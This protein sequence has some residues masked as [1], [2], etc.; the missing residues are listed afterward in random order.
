MSKEQLPENL[1]P[2]DLAEALLQKLKTGATLDPTL[3]H[4]LLESLADKPSTGPTADEDVKTA[5]SGTTEALMSVT[6]KVSLDS[7][8]PRNENET[9]V[10]R[11][12]KAYKMLVKKQTNPEF[13]EEE[14]A[15]SEWYRQEFDMKRPELHRAMI[16]LL[17]DYGATIDI[18]DVNY[19]FN[20]LSRG[21][22]EWFKLSLS[23]HVSGVPKGFSEGEL[24]EI[25][26]RLIQRYLDE[27]P[28]DEDD[29]YNS[30]RLWYLYLIRPDV[31]CYERGEDIQS[32]IGGAIDGYG[33]QEAA[34]PDRAAYVR[35]ILKDTLA[36]LDREKEV[37]AKLDELRK[38]Y[39]KPEYAI[40][41]KPS[42]SGKGNGNIVVSRHKVSGGMVDYSDVVETIT[43]EKP[44]IASDFNVIR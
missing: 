41:F 21:K 33:S 31:F 44:M 40:R 27:I 39:P 5:V 38:R 25:R 43:P 1:G 23:G 16:D 20:I 30:Q 37:V 6:G 19:F 3:R 26:R 2:N 28:E 11:A 18:D 15:E 10:L 32:L 17:R 34:R 7:I 36:N 29:P 24:L 12:V 14:R 8:Q 13:T 9:V 35:G 42:G 4:Q 22:Q